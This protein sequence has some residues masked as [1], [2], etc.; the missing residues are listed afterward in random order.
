MAIVA[1]LRDS[2]GALVAIN[3]YTPDSPAGL[4][5]LVNA[6]AAATGSEVVTSGALS[7]AVYLSEL[8][9]SGSKSYTLAAPTVAGQRKRIECTVAGNT[10]VGT[11]TV[12]SPDD[13]SGSVCAGTFK[14]DTVGQAIELVGTADLKWRATRVQRAGGTA[15]NVVIGTTVLTGRNLW[16]RYMCSVTGTVSSTGTKAL[17]DG[18]AVGE[19]IILACSS[20]ASTPNGNIAFTGKTI[21]GGAVTDASALGSTTDVM[22]LEWDGTAWQVMNSTGITFT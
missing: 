8:S 21:I 3:G 18:S 9:I 2:D 13:T 22:T 17:P 1:G 20:V 7:L 12:S 6:T 4:Q 15:G 19:R 5:A 14:F 16:M 10:P 11:L